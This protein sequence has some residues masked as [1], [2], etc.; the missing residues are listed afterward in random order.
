MGAK[1]KNESTYTVQDK[2]HIDIYFSE[3]AVNKKMSEWTQENG[4]LR[5][6]TTG[7]KS[8]KTSSKA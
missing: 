8:D 6:A 3:A 4:I 2:M 1:P 5:T 7:L